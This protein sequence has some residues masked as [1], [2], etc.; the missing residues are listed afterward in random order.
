MD[1]ELSTV[2]VEVEAVL[3]SRPLTYIAAEE[4][5]ELLTPAHLV[6]GRRLI[7]LLEINVDPDFLAPSDRPSITARMEHIQRLLKEA[8][9]R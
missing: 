7:G 8:P 9:K 2:I 6:T 5:E 4:I 1:D 3:N